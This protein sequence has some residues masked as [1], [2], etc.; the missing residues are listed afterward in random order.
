MVRR[1]PRRAGIYAVKTVDGGDLAAPRDAALDGR[2]AAKQR[3]RQLS[4]G[5][6]A[7]NGGGGKTATAAG[8]RAQALTVHRGGGG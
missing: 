6:Q 3:R 7:L 1:S 5:K 8:G 2:A 4:Q